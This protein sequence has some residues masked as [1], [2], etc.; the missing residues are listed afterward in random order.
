MKGAQ[1]PTKGLD[2]GKDFGILAVSPVVEIAEGDDLEEVEQ[3]GRLFASRH[4]QLPVELPPDRGK[5]L[6]QPLLL[7]VTPGVEIVAVRRTGDSRQSMF[8][9][10]LAADQ[11]GEGGT[12]TFALALLAV[13]TSAHLRGDPSL[14]DFLGSTNP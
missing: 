13:D 6:A 8:P 2:G 1:G 12:G 9:A 5:L 4:T 11:T 10:A 7:V 14:S 3:R